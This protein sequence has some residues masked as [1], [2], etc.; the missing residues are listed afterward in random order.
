MEQGSK[1]F[2]NSQPDLGKKR[3]QKQVISTGT[4]TTGSETPRSQKRGRP[5]ADD[6]E[7]YRA[8]SGKKAKLS[9]TAESSTALAKAQS[10]PSAVVTDPVLLRRRAAIARGRQ[11]NRAIN[12]HGKEPGSIPGAHP[13]QRG[14]GSLPKIDQ[15]KK[16]GVRSSVGKTSSNIYEFPDSEDD[17]PSTGTNKKRGEQHVVSRQESSVQR[18]GGRPRRASSYEP[19]ELSQNGTSIKRAES[20]KR[21]GRK[22]TELRASGNMSDNDQEASD[23]EQTN[24]RSSPKTSTRRRKST[25]KAIEAR[26]EPRKPKGVLTPLK[27]TPVGRRRKSVAF[28]AGKENGQVEVYFEDLPSKPVKTPAVLPSTKSATVKPTADKTADVAADDEDEEVCVICAKPDSAP[29]NEIMF[30]DGCDMAVHQECYGISTIPEGDW[31]CRD[32]L[33]DDTITTDTVPNIKVGNQVPDIP[34]FEQHLRSTQRVLIDRCTGRR[35]IKLRG[36]DEAYG[37]AFQLLEQTV[38]AG[39]GNSMLVI[40]ARGS[41]KTTVGQIFP[42]W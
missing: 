25:Q 2:P 24:G 30:C 3:N 6:G 13:G 16:R 31:L 41:G 38:V 7:N 36:E 37:K 10:E 26:T 17:E 19:N 14:T 28:D 1:F 23:R 40:G 15:A 27:G 22:S 5:R 4:M 39:E 9:S 32:C 21:S 34:N 33:R 29:P 35:R 42:P 12:G 18:K 20:K 8:V 11:N